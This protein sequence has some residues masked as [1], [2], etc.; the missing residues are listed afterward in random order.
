MTVRK[1]IR[2]GTRRSPLAIWQAEHIQHLLETRAP[3]L[4]CTLVRIVTQGDK[5]LDVPLSQVGGKGL[6]VNEIENSLLRGE[7]DLAVHSMKDLPAQLH[8]GLVLAAIPPREDPRDVLICR[9][10]AHRLESL[11]PGSRV[12]TSSLRRASW[13]RSLRPDLTTEPSRGNVETR[14]RKL[15]EGHFLAIVLAMAGLKRLG[16][17]HR[18]TEI[19]SP[20]RCLPAI[21]QGALALECRASDKELL[22]M[23]TFLHDPVTA[24]AIR[25]ERSFLAEV[26][27]GC[28]VPVACHGTLS[29]GILILSG[30]VASLDGSVCIRRRTEGNPTDAEKM[31]KELA[32]EILDAGGTQVLA[33]IRTGV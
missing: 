10:K 29:D 1:T 28:Q 30:Q 27:G 18:V 21:G 22:E 9:D 17:D 12:G 32:R 3:G 26:E 24:C 4:T 15:D 14:L 5:L 31:G 13:I 7:C 23:L 33:S 2:I 6:F 19:F 8:D 20:E 11:P 25:G 16:L